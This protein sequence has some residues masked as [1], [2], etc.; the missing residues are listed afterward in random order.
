MPDPTPRHCPTCARYP[1]AYRIGYA[2]AY[3]GVLENRSTRPK[4]PPTVEDERHWWLA[5]WHGQDAGQCAAGRRP[6]DPLSPA[7]Y[8]AARGMVCP[9]CGSEDITVDVDVS[10]SDLHTVVQAADCLACRA[11]W[12]ALYTVTGYADLVLDEER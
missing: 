12:Q 6:P 3:E 4:V 7:D 11:Y 9:A 10:R 5:Y 2:E 8:A 1:H